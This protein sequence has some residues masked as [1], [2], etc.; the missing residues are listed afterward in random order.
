MLAEKILLLLLT[1]QFTVG[2]AKGGEKINVV[3]KQEEGYHVHIKRFHFLSGGSVDNI[4]IPCVPRGSITRNQSAVL[5]TFL[6]R[7]FTQKYL[8]LKGFQEQQIIYNK[9]QK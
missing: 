9:I 2:N 7:A 8:L 5:R 1:R 6:Q 4:F 3:V